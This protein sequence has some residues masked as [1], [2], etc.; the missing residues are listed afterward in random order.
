MWWRTTED[1]IKNTRRPWNEV[2]GIAGDH[3]TWKL[4]M[5]ALCYTSSKRTQKWWFHEKKYTP[6]LKSSK[7]FFLMPKFRHFTV[8]WQTIQALQSH[9]TDNSYRWTLSELPSHRT[10]STAHSFILTGISRQTP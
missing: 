4:F 3:N 8:M 10:S 9:V 7:L 2:K 5:D 1:E 6:H